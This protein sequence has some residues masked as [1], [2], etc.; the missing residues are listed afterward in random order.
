MKIYIQLS[1]QNKLKVT[2]GRTLAPQ[3]AHR[4]RLKE[5]SEVKV[6]LIKQLIYV[7]KQNW[8]VKNKQV[9]KSQ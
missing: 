4:N 6:C 7:D 1:Q 9:K 8:R 5:T 3:N 2:S